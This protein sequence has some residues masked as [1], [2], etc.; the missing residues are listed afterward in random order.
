MTGGA[1]RYL[2]PEDFLREWARVAADEQGVPETGIAV[3]SGLRRFVTASAP[4]S[5]HSPNTNRPNL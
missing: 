1:G 5:A 4:I 2:L 3:G